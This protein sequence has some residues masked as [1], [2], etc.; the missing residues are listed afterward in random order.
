M[1]FIGAD[2]VSDVGDCGFDIS[3]HNFDGAQMVNL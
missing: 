1:F 2:N 3:G